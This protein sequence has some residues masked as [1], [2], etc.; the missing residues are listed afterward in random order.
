[1]TEIPIASFPRSLDP[2]FVELSERMRQEAE[3]AGRRYAEGL[4][5]HAEYRAALDRLTRLVLYGEKPDAEAHGE[6]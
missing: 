2:Q 4:C 6:R 5:G 3:A 1:M